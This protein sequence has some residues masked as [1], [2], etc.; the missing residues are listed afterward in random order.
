M[1]TGFVYI[2]LNLCL[3]VSFFQLWVLCLYLYSLFVEVVDVVVR[4]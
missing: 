2:V 3:G 4:G 1:D